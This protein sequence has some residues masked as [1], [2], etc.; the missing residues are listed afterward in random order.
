MEL[1]EKKE[2]RR[3]PL[4]KGFEGWCGR[5][6]LRIGQ[7]RWKSCQKSAELKVAVTKASSLLNS[8]AGVEKAQ[9]RQDAGVTK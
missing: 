1:K 5:T 6:F 8:R 9:D 7:H 3:G 4:L 2:F